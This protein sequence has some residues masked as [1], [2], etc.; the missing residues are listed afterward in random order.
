LSV[1]NRNSVI[2]GVQLE[3]GNWHWR[4]LL[5]PRTGHTWAAP[6]VLLDGRLAKK[7]TDIIDRR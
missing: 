6:S 7:F 2:P 3:C 4:A 1:S 5:P